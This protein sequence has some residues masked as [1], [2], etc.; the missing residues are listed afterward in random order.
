MHILVTGPA[1]RRGNL[2]SALTEP[3]SHESLSIAFTE[4]PDQAVLSTCD[5]LIDLEFDM[6]P[7][8]LRVYLEKTHPEAFFILHA[9]TLS[10]RETAHS[11]N[12]VHLLHRVAGVNAWPGCLDGP[13]WEMSTCHDA[14]HETLE[15]LSKTVGFEYE[16]VADRV[17]LVTPRVMC[18]IINEAYLTLQEGTAGRSDI[19][20]AMKLGTNYPGGPFEWA[21]RWGLHEVSRMLQCLQSATG[22]PRYKRSQLLIEEAM[23]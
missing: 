23:T 7:E 10:L 1:D 9:N 21:E 19:D 6:H 22:D 16:R 15:H 8:I 11:F 3:S 14:A 17:G 13:L 18:M 2:L 12:L 5:L 20:L 4:T